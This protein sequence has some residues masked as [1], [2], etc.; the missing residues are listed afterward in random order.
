MI[1]YDRIE[2]WN[3]NV[4]NIKKLILI[5]WEGNTNNALHKIDA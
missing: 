4:I 3:V 2:F 1:K 5:T